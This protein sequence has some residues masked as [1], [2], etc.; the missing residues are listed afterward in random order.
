MNQANLNRASNIRT[1]AWKH[2]KTNIRKDKA[3]HFRRKNMVASKDETSVFQIEN[4]V[5]AISSVKKNWGHHILGF[6]HAVWQKRF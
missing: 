1:T 3:L 5:E 4:I 6:R 2:G